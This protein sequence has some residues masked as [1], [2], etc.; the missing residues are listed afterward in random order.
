MENS[1]VVFIQATL[2]AVSLLFPLYGAI[3]F[4][5]EPEKGRISS[6]PFYLRLTFM[7]VDFFVRFRC[8]SAFV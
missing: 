5:R 3:V 4:T 7:L 1:D 6:R 8:F 2:L